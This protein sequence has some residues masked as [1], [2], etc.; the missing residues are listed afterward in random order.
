MRPVRLNFQLWNCGNNVPQVIG[1]SAAIVTA[2][3]T[4]YANQTTGLISGSVYGNDQISCGGIQSTE[5]LV[6]EYKARASNHKARRWPGRR[7]P[8]CR[9]VGAD[10]LFVPSDSQF[11]VLPSRT[12]GPSFCGLMTK[13]LIRLAR[14]ADLMFSGILVITSQKAVSGA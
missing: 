10:R 1:N 13:E 4:L 11:L 3:F 12:P 5:W 7:W 2:Q 6:T 14:F 8:S 9:S